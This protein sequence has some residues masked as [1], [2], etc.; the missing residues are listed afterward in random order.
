M[1]T[2]AYY[3]IPTAEGRFKYNAK[4]LAIY[5]TKEELFNDV[6][7]KTKKVTV[8]KTTKEI[9]DNNGMDINNIVFVAMDELYEGKLHLTQ[10]KKASCSSPK[11]NWLL[12]NNTSKKVF[13]FG[14]LKLPFC[15]DVLL[16]Y[17]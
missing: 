2:L 17:S 14:V 9:V 1:E 4:I 16:N 5:K 8:N 3:T 15:M 13:H 6:I 7:R 11:N 10:L 12:F